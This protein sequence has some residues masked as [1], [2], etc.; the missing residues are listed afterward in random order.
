MEFQGLDDFSQ[1]TKRFFRQGTGAFFTASSGTGG[2]GHLR[3]TLI[4]ARLT[5]NHSHCQNDA[6]TPRLVLQCPPL[7]ASFLLWV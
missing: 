7:R 5:E 1:G 6:H 4:W 2:L 3:I